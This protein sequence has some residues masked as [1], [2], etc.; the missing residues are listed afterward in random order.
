MQGFPAASGN[1]IDRF[2][3]GLVEQTAAQKKQRRRIF[4]DANG[5]EG[6]RA[7]TVGFLSL[8]CSGRGR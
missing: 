1:K 7:N 6:E 4:P 8:T 2:P 3:V 5:Q